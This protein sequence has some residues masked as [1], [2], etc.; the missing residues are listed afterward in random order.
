DKESYDD[1]ALAQLKWLGTHVDYGESKATAKSRIDMAGVCH[2]ETS[3]RDVRRRKPISRPIARHVELLA[4]KNNSRLPGLQGNLL[5]RLK[6]TGR[7]LLRF[8]RKKHF[9]NM[10]VD[11]T[12]LDMR[13]F[14]L[15]IGDIEP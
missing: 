11:R 15:P 2:Q 5:A 4:S 6:N 1:I 12:R 14:V 9:S 3:R 8:A 7:C 10:E 13:F